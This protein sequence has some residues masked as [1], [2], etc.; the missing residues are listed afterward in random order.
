LI[1]GVG[2]VIPDATGIPRFLLRRWC[3]DWHFQRIADAS[4][5][6]PENED[7]LTLSISAG[8]DAFV[9][10]VEFIVAVHQIWRIDVSAALEMIVRRCRASYPNL[11]NRPLPIWAR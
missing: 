11:R 8:D 5:L 7:A 3:D 2:H 10:E 1:D 4:L 9:G 6:A